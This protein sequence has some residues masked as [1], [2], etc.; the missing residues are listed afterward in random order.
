MLGVNV[1]GVALI[2]LM[3]VAVRARSA[4]A[5]T[6]VQALGGLW[7]RG[8][9]TLGLRQLTGLRLPRAFMALLFSMVFQIAVAFTLHLLGIVPKD[10]L[11]AL[12]Y[13]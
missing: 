4:G 5:V 11:K 8:V 12:L 2:P 3:T 9:G 1:I 10:I 13:A 6:T 7:M